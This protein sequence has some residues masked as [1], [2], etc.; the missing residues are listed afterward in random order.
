MSHAQ[1]VFGRRGAPSPAQSPAVAAPAKLAADAAPSAAYLEI[2]AAARA[3][4]SGAGGDADPLDASAAAT[5]PATDDA[6]L[7]AYLGPAFYRYED[8]WRRCAGAPGLRSSFSWPAAIFGGVWLLYRKLYVLGALLVVAQAT[9]LLLPFLWA[10]IGELAIAAVLNRY[11]K[12]IV[13]MAAWRKVRA[14]RRNSATPGAAEREIEAAGG[15]SFLAP[16]LGVMLLAGTLYG[17]MQQVASAPMTD[18]PDWRALEA[19]FPAN[20]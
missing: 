4:F 3:A 10:R 19:L 13:L 1:P 12:S 14:I 2:A 7:R 5:R 16:A 18:L 9:L 6:D 20:E 17:A 11:G 15:V 8:L